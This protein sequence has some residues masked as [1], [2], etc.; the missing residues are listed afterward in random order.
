M[1]EFFIYFLIYSFFGFI[2]ETSYVYLMDGELKERGFLFGPVIPIYGF[3]AM[4][5][6]TCLHPFEKQIPQLFIYGMILTSTLEYITS[7]IME[8]AFG[9]RWWDYSVRKYNI[10]GRICLRNSLMFAL[11]SVILMQWIHPTVRNL[12]SFYKGPSMDVFAYLTFLLISVDFILSIFGAFNFK[13]H[14][15]EIQRLRLLV[16]E[17]LSEENIK[18]SMRD[19]INQK[20]EFFHNLDYRYLSLQENIKSRNEKFKKY[21]K[22]LLSRFPNISSKRFE[23]ILEYI[24]DL[25]RKDLE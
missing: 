16:Q 18:L 5:I 9:M 17:L 4:A 20:D 2:I 21:Q 23:Q 15:V 1:T 10:K 3:G 8:K 11:L 22:R 25:N 12:I 19:F 6:I 14:V 24:K 13:K 7:Y